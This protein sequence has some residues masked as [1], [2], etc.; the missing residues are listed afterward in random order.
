MIS[1]QGSEQFFFCPVPFSGKSHCL[2][3]NQNER[4]SVENLNAVC[5]LGKAVAEKE[6]LLD[7]H[8]TKESVDQLF[9]RN[10]TQM[11]LHY[12]LV[13]QGV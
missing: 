3:L 5:F 13:R 10:L 12:E 4:H 1:R 6:D 9:L 11:G 2:L 7:P 8:G